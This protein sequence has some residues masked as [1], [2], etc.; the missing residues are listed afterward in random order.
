MKN[1][2]FLFP[3]SACS[4]RACTVIMGA[5][6][7]NLVATHA[8]LYSILRF[9]FTPWAWF[10]SA[11]DDLM[12]ECKLNPSDCDVTQQVIIYICITVKPINKIHSWK[13]DNMTFIDKCFCNQKEIFTYFFGGYKKYNCRWALVNMYKH[14]H[15]CYKKLYMI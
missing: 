4:V 1:N 6:D 12:I 8:L 15:Y 14:F 2:S 11:E 13:R 10:T 7:A 9:S 3:S 5:F